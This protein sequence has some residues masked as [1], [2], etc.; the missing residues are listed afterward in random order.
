MTLNTF[1]TYQRGGLSNLTK[2]ED[3]LF[4]ITE[5]LTKPTPCCTKPLPKEH[6]PTQ[7][8]KA[9]NELD[10]LVWTKRPHTFLSAEIKTW[11]FV[12]RVS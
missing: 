10:K 11:R 7:S 9:S 8:F 2:D 5:P 12:A 4:M 1:K 6:L 3:N